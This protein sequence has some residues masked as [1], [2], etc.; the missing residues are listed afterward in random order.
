MQSLHQ[1]RQ[2]GERLRQ[3]YIANKDSSRA[4]STTQLD[5]SQQL[6]KKD[7]KKGDTTRTLSPT[8]R[9]DKA[10]RTST[11]SLGLAP[12]PRLSSTKSSGRPTINL[13]RSISGISV[14]DR[15]ITGNTVKPG[16]AKSKV[17]VVEPGDEDANMSAR[18]W[19]L[20]LKMWAT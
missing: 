1:Y 5:D 11:L 18:K 15:P 4:L 10:G 19:G 8:N 13:I 9:I 16:N 6:T 12:D 17:Y 7:L 20:P 3:Q 2:L 14:Q